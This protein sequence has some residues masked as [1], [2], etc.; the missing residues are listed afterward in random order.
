MNETDSLPDRRRSRAVLIGTSTFDHLPPLPAVRNNLDDLWAALTDVKHGIIAP[1]NC[2]VIADPR[3]ARVFMTGLRGV[4]DRTDDF[5]LV[6]YAGHGLRHHSKDELYL[7]V[8]ESEDDALDESA[9]RFERVKEVLQ[10]GPA[11]RTL[12]VLDCCYSGMALGTMSGPPIEQWEIA[13][14]G[15]AVMA[16]SPKNR[17]SHSPVGDRN[18]AFTGRMISLLKN[19]SPIA[20]EPLTVS[21]L[22][23]RMSVALV[24]G[25]FPRPL[26]K[27]TET[28]GD[29]LVRRPAPAP[30]KGREPRTVPAIRPIAPPIP[31]AGTPAP[32][33]VAP[34]SSSVP[35]V[36]GPPSQPVMAPAPVVVQA[37]K[38]PA[39][40]AVQAK[41]RVLQVLW[42]LTAV[43]LA[44]VTG[45]LVGLMV[46]DEPVRGSGSSAGATLASG[47][48][49]TAIFGG[50]V[51]LL[52][53]RWGNLGQ[54]H[55]QPVLS[56]STAGR[57]VLLV[58]IAFFAILAV[59]VPLTD[60]PTGSTVATMVGA[61]LIPIEAAAGCVYLLVRGQ[62]LR[63]A[64]GR[65]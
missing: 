37:T 52:R 50:S 30:A 49:L 42:V 5:L 21:S 20:S 32:P 19:G 31:P 56:R 46:G 39:A 25:R 16:S 53:H 14:R 64:S 23:K 40:A 6:Y 65:H 34:A 47:A 18:T 59:V 2:E 57:V 36:S 24:E 26:I 29:L 48:T 35:F 10:D 43:S 63:R 15:S 61:T 27:L 11:R 44:M 28:S 41:V 13:V 22:Y 51:V 38:A 12:L 62:R 7:S 58:G 8:R 9:V 54:S 3:S 33:V 60:P 4:V 55:V 45:G 1:E 17:K